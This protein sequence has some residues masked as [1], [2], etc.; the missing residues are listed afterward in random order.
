MSTSL[1]WQPAQPPSS[2]CM[3]DALKFVLRKRHG[4]GFDVT[5]TTEDADYG[6]VKGLIDA[7][8]DGA[9]S[10]MKALKKHGRIRVWEEG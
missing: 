8:V 7:G 6:Y 1:Y 9:E 5:L 4:D 10:L 2:R 3:P